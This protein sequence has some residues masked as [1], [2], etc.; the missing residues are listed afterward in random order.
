MIPEIEN[1]V[2]YPIYD[3]IAFGGRKQKPLAKVM[4]H[5]VPTECVAMIFSEKAQH[6]RFPETQQLSD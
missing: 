3:G 5:G 6:E 4:Q 1:S 2:N